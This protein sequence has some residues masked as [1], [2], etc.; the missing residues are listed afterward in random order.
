MDDGYTRNNTCSVI[1]KDLDGVLL[2]CITPHP[3]NP[4]RVFDFLHQWYSG[5]TTFSKLAVNSTLSQMQYTGQSMQ[6]YISRWERTS[7]QRKSTGPPTD[8]G[9][10]VMK[11][12]ESFVDRSNSPCGTDLFALQKSG[13]HTWQLVTSRLLQKFRSEQESKTMGET[14]QDKA[15]VVQPTK[16]NKERAGTTPASMAWSAAIATK[17]TTSIWNASDGSKN[18]KKKTQTRRITLRRR[19]WLRL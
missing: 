1:R 13:D 17:V 2:A 14:S 10:L 4:R 7:V 11:V 19:F 9:F 16:S 18:I 3:D 15:F 5:I 6:Y 8:D 12:I